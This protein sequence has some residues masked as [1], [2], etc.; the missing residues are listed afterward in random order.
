MAAAEVAPP[1][2]ASI[3]LEHVPSYAYAEI[4]AVE[5]HAYADTSH[6]ES[7]YAYAQEAA[8]QAQRAMEMP[9][10]AAPV[11]AAP[12]AEAAPVAQPAEDHVVRESRKPQTAVVSAE[13]AELLVAR[14]SD[15]MLA[16]VVDGA[17]V[18]L[19]FLAAA[20]VVIASTEHPPTGKIALIAS[21][22]GLAL[23][24]LLY[25]Y[26]FLSYAEEGTPGMR[27]ARIALC[28]FCDE[29]PT[30]QQMQMRIPA[31]VLATVPAGLGLVWALFDG[32]KL[33]WHDRLTKTYQ[34]KY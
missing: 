15:R 18:M 9:E 1:E 22:F 2:W 3:E 12:V 13:P 26:L 23:F 29:N 8:V 21:G 4:E 24:Y 5:H 6:L 19:A 31:M 16:G 25:Q 33:G 14:V 20:V 30:R 17:L 34:R 11:Y 10:V 7:Q 27:Y 28:T 32:E